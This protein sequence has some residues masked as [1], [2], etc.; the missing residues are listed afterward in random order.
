MELALLETLAEHGSLATAEIADR[1][2][3]DGAT[4][5]VVLQRMQPRGLVGVLPSA[6]VSAHVAEPATRWQL[7]G[8]GRKELARLRTV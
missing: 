1:V 5:R 2:G 4:T 7:T 8:E 6:D 3:A